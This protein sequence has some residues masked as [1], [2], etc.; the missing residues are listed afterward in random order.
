MGC[1]PA[2]LISACYSQA[3]SCL[4]DCLPAAQSKSPNL[5]NPFKHWQ[6][7]R[8]H[9]EGNLCARG[10]EARPARAAG[11]HGEPLCTVQGPR[12]VKVGCTSASLWHQHDME[13]GA[14]APT[15]LPQ[16]GSLSFGGFWVVSEVKP[17]VLS[18]WGMMLL[19]PSCSAPM[20]AVALLRSLWFQE[21]Q[22][23]T[24]SCPLYCS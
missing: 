1:G 21:V 24:C 9:I 14:Q 8:Q 17:K 7:K 11:A 16:Q 13:M 6:M 2:L 15:V 22:T 12:W 23:V 20:G 4:T 5:F 18:S 19:A 10:T 3:G